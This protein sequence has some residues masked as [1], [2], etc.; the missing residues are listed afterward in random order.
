MGEEDVPLRPDD[1]FA[2]D[3]ARFVDGRVDPSTNTR[4][5]GGSELDVLAVLEAEEQLRRIVG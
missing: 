2:V 5:P 1:R 4:P 3:V